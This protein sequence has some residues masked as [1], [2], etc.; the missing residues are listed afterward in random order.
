MKY[1][2]IYLQPPLKVNG[3]QQ[4]KR[5]KILQIEAE[6]SQESCRHER[7]TFRVP[8][9]PPLGTSDNDFNLFN[10]WACINIWR[11]NFPSDMYCTQ[12]CGPCQA[13]TFCGDCICVCWQHWHCAAVLEWYNKAEFLCRA[14]SEV[15]RKHCSWVFEWSFGSWVLL[16]RMRWMSQSFYFPVRLF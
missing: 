6:N 5:C 11:L 8:L 3:I 2:H 9:G 4:K 15:W 13:P 7:K 1:A 12:M 14:T 16:G 10:Y